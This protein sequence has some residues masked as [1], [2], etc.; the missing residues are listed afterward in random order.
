MDGY[1]HGEQN[2]RN[3][4]TIIKDKLKFKSAQN[5]ISTELFRKINEGSTI[6]VHF[7]RFNVINKYNNLNKDYYLRAVEI[8]ENKLY[9]PIYY[10]F[11]DYKLNSNLEDIFPN[12]RY[13]I[14]D[15][16]HNEKVHL[17][18]CG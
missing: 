16:N 11:S 7:R 17:L 4:A 8:L 3:I 1:F 18:I 2:F 5:L 6:A 10:I 15:T 13:F 12:N 9:K 14:I